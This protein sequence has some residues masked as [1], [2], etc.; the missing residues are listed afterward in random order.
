[1][2]KGM[3]E[4]L[5]LW[6]RGF[7]RRR[8]RERERLLEQLRSA[9]ATATATGT[10]PG[11]RAVPGGGKYVDS[12]AGGTPLLGDRR[13][14]F[15]PLLVE[16]YAYGLTQ[17]R[18]SFVVS[19]V[20]AAFGAGILLL[21]VALA[22]WKAETTGDLYAGIVT[23]SV[24]VV[25]T[26]IGQLFHRRADLALRHMA[27]QTAALRDDR[28]TAETTQQAVQLLADVADPALRARLQ[29][30]LIMKLSG[31]VLPEA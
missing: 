23:S 7:D 14:D 4:W 16:Y 6:G 25:V 13:D 30:G 15:T 19:Q 26:L 18:S 29:A 3:A 27:E 11:P 21:G 28:R 20:F 10:V 2:A 22:V 24:G 12:S 9:T 17:A 8:E 1:M 5:G 31:A